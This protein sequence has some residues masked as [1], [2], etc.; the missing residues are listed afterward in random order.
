MRDSRSLPF[1]L[2]R[3]Q[4]FAAAATALIAALVL[5][6]WTFR[7]E[8]LKRIVPGMVA[9]NPLTALV[10]F[11]AAISLALVP[12]RSQ[13]TLD[14]R[15]RLLAKISAVAVVAVG[16]LRFLALIGGPDLKIDQIL[17]AAQLDYGFRFRNVM[18]PNTAL[19]FILLGN[20]L[21]LLHAG[22]RRTRPLVTVAAS[23]CGF[24]SILAVV[25][26]LYDIDAFYGL[27]AFVPM[28][29][30]TA[31]AFLFLTFGVLACQANR[32]MLAAITGTNIGGTM[33]RRLLPAAILVPVIIG[34][35]R[36]EAQR[37]GYFGSE[38][39]VA[40]YTVMNMLVLSALVAGNAVLLFRID[41]ARAKADLQ[42]KRAHDRLEINVAE[43]TAQLSQAN[44]ELQ[45]AHAQLEARVRERTATL[46]QSEAKLQALLDHMTPIVFMKDLAGRYQLVN[47][48]FEHVFGFA[49]GSVCGK[50]ATELFPK[51]A[52]EPSN[53]DDRQIIATGKSLHFEKTIEVRNGV[54]TF[55]STKFPLLDAA[56]K[57]YATCGISTDI[58]DRARAEQAVQQAKEEAD[59]A[60]RAKSEF[61][62]RMSHE[63]RT[64]MNAILGF[65]QLLELEDLSADQHESVTHI[66]GG[67][68]HLLELINEV[69]DI[70]RIEAGRLALS[71][72]PV[73]LTAALRE[74]IDLVR[75]LAADRELALTMNPIAEC[76]VLADRQRFKQVLINLV[77][78]AIKYNR[79]GGSVT[80]TCQP[81]EA[82]V[83]ILIQ[84]TGMGI[85]A[86]QISQLFTPFERLSADRGS[87]EG[88]GLGL[89]VARRLVEAMDGTIGF[90]SVPGE[91]STFWVEIPLTVSPLQRNDLQLDETET[92]VLDG[93]EQHCVLYIEDNL[94]NVRLIEQVL[95]RRPA[96]Q[97]LTAMN[98]TDGIQV[99]QQ[100]TPELVLLDL[101]LPDMHG[102]EVL[103][104]LHADPR[105]SEIPV[106]VITADAMNEQREQLTAEGALDYLTKPIDIKKFLEVLDRS[107]AASE[108]D[109]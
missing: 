71:T 4:V 45:S 43:R 34:W 51:D 13:R 79:V 60:S 10:F 90:E 62:S 18:A 12:R 107:L 93:S 52:G 36:I 74:T 98:G 2:H 24:E 44:A 87:I 40:L 28:A 70:S 42:L 96:I 109:S 102:H 68:R 20:A 39:G 77:S 105:T 7:L 17:F 56:G 32:G 53:E 33:A 11:L 97:L 25:G 94:S 85:P 21:W 101:N 26:Y 88:T 23:V 6:G 100:A 66:I 61:L 49:E 59:R 80:I 30:P 92:T 9:M 108:N 106:V 73:E 104:Q 15:L 64:P 41:A 84:D 58:T 83:R 103:K 57:V 99:A 76:F 82:R 54:R 35:L 63:L 47:R 67:G 1:N 5:L 3:P 86:D 37:A 48:R 55:L 38:F 89:A 75:T 78:N 95:A 22:L 72:E 46:A 91:G 69:L 29:L 19:N 8:H 16:A 31:I 27:R 81:G 14:P 65:A 50:T